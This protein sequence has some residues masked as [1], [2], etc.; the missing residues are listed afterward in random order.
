MMKKEN[1]FLNYIKEHY[2]GLIV[3]FFG[4]CGTIAAFSLLRDRIQY[5]IDPNF[6]PA[7]N[8]NPL[9]DCGSVMRSRWASIFGFPNTMIGLMTYPLSIF[10][11]I[12]MIANKENN[13]F[14][15]RGTLIL[16]G[17]G[18]ILNI[19]LLYTSAFLIGALCP[20]CL[21]AG[22]ATSN[23]F[24]GILTHSIQKGYLTDDAQKQEKLNKLIKNG[25]NIKLI[26]LYYI[27]IG[28]FVYLG[29]FSVRWLV[30][31]GYDYQF[32]NL[33]FWVK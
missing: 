27:L 25:F 28:L 31:A 13:K 30:E 24:F 16:S 20:W 14:L 33:L 32:P 19:L 2:L 22:T 4:I 21:L 6:V 11:G 18:V 9:L 1:K 15:M 10:T 26:I 29:F 17:I 5:Y 8:I 3:I 12:I 23:V 7:C